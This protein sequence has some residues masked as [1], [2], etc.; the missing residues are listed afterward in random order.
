MKTTILIT[1]LS[2]FYT[3]ILTAQFSNFTERDKIVASDRAAWDYYG[4]TVAISGK[5]AIVGVP[6]GD[7][8]TAG[9]NF[10]ERA[11]AAYI[12]ERNAQGDWV[13]V[14]KIM[15]FDR[16][17]LDEFGLS[18]TVDGD[19]IA[20]GSYTNRATGG[21]SP[22]GYKTG[23]VYIYERNNL[24]GHWDFA[25]KVIASDRVTYTQFCK[26]DISG[27]RMIVG[28]DGSNTGTNPNGTTGGG[29]VYFFERN[30][31][32][33]WIEQQKYIP[34]FR[35]GSDQLGY[36]VAICGDYAVAGAPG[37]N[38]NYGYAHVGP[39]LGTAFAMQYTSSNGWQAM[40]V[41][42]SNSGKFQAGGNQM[43]AKCGYAVDIDTTNGVS[44]I[45][46]EP[47]YD[48]SASRL[49][50]GRV[51]ITRFFGTGSN[52]RT[53][54]VDNGSIG[55]SV[56]IDQGN[57]AIGRIGNLNGGGVSLAHYDTAASQWNYDS[58]VY[59][60]STSTTFPVRDSVGFS[61]AIS[62]QNVMVGATGE[63]EDGSNNNTLSS[64]GAV[65]VF[66]ECALDS[67]IVTV[68]ACNNYTSPSG[69]Y[70]WTTSGTFSDT[71][72]NH[73]G[74]DSVLIINLTIQA[75]DT[76]VMI[77][78]TTLSSNNS[79][80]T[81]QW[82]DCTTNQ[83]ILG[84]NNAS[85]TPLASGNYAVVVSGNGCSDTSDC[86]AMTVV[87]IEQVQSIGQFSIYP[88]PTTG[89]LNIDLGKRAKNISLEIV[90]V[91]GQVIFANQTKEAELMNI[92]I[93]HL[94]SGIYFVRIQTEAKEQALIK[95]IK[96]N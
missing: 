86:I 77:N 13:E 60:A 7:L 94:D 59:T 70:Q 26:V 52:F 82:I 38:R 11:G 57:A 90:T 32:G 74:C 15:A 45:V 37:H 68:N 55:I 47:F 24:T 20:V 14:Q 80:G 83:A 81:Y 42:F 95:L 65:Y 63:D 9:I 56:S 6:Q 93:S 61:V 2:I 79:L 43:G 8:D 78:G 27:N 92:D 49:D 76:S 50:V 64:A 34:N 10:L 5:Y 22:F 3:S 84:A 58:Q 19:Y 85:F 39:D 33:Q 1:L 51:Y 91:T 28:A 48:R 29:A 73:L 46:G 21:T 40:P 17:A 44:C 53:G 18:V 89:H 36:S 75:I 35:S 41:G 54:T 87:N 12:L 72:N 30:G 71:L 96:T 31:A 88:N 66:T 4:T 25:Q 67:T 62:G 16:R 23:G 69:Q